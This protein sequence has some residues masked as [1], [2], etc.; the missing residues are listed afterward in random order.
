MADKEPVGVLAI[1]TSPDGQVIATASDFERQAPGGYKLWEAQ[2]YRARQQVMWATVRAYC[3]DAIVDAITDYL[4]TQIA[5]A[6]CRKGHRI[7]I[8]AI[9]WNEE[10]SAEV[11]RS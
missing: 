4:S 5:E 2:R 9:G 8:K 3:S 6:L 1:M 10:I 11:A 7:T